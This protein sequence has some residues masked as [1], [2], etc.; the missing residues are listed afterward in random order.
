MMMMTTTTD[1]VTCRTAAYVAIFLVSLST[2]HSASAW[3]N[4]RRKFSFDLILSFFQARV[5]LLPS[6]IFFEMRKPTRSS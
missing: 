4:D 6:D 1:K 5:S 2:L 3:R